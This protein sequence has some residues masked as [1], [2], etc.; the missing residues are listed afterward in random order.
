MLGRPPEEARVVLKL[1][2]VV[3]D[4]ADE[5]GLLGVVLGEVYLYSSKT[6]VCSH[7][8]GCRG[9]PIARAGC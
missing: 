5:P 2:C 6:N 9:E 1:H 8:Q 4:T 7:S 3:A